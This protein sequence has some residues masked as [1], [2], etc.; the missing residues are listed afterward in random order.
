MR[1]KFPAMKTDIGHITYLAQH[2]YPPLSTHVLIVSGFSS[3]GALTRAG[4]SPTLPLHFKNHFVPLYLAVEG[5]TH[6]CLV[7]FKCN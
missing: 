4:L 6:V 1:D 7:I 3:F 5:R 2:Q